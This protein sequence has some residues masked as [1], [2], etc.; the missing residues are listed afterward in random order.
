MT[1]IGLAYN[2]KPDGLTAF[3]DAVRAVHPGTGAEPATDA[4][5]PHGAP[6]AH[7]TA[8]LESSDDE[9]AEWDDASTVDAV[10]AALAPL[11]SVIRLEA[12][13]DFPG[14]AA[15]E[16]PDIVFNMA[17]GRRGPNREAHIP[18]ILEFLGIPYTASDP[19][20]LSLCL[21]KARTKE[22]LHYR[23][24]PTAPF[25]V[26]TSLDGIEPLERRSF[27]MF[28]KPVHEG[29][30]K[31]ISVRSVCPDVASLR[32]QV[33]HLLQRYR[34]PVLV[35]SYLPGE[36]FTCAL[37]G[38]ADDVAVLPLVGLRFDAL[39]DGAPPIY[40]FEAKWIWDTADRP[41]GIFEC[42]AHIDE[43]LL[44]V[45]ELI[46]LRAYHAVGCRD[47]ARIDVRLDARG[48]PNVLDVNPLPGILPDPNQHSCLPLA[49]R[50]AGIGYEELIQRCLLLGAERQ[51]VRI[52][53]APVFPRVR[54]RTPPHGIPLR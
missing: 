36:E 25:A 26:V 23:G 29:S 18:A 8:S 54:R 30:S 52:P 45:I 2:V 17:E 34:Q 10:E 11:G 9:F 4:P 35:E 22:T 46:A 31:G 27:P 32:E 20:T 53:A 43:G 50:T 13:D 19:F 16:R 49:A 33:A 5:L 51:G 47:W 28:V 42:P 41:I 1:R 3:N 40:G 24:I 39:P 48:M 7:A 21:D 15:R 14:R 6:A 12:D 37:L 44:E 38:N